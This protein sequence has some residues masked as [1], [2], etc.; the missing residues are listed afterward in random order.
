MKFKYPMDTPA[1]RAKVYRLAIKALPIKTFI[2]HAIFYVLIGDQWKEW[3]AD[4]KDKKA[5]SIFPEVTAYKPVKSHIC[6]AWADLLKQ[7]GETELT[8]RV[9]ILEQAIEDCKK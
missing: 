9:R 1:Q 2:C 5:Y 6:H 4:T 7:P 3:L 8:V